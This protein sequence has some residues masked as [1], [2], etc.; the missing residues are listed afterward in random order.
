[1]AQPTRVAL[2]DLNG[3][4]Y[5]GSSKETFYRYI[6][7]KHGIKTFN[8][9]RQKAVGLLHQT[10]LMGQ[11]E[12]KENFFRYLDGLPPERVAQ[13]AR[14]FWSIEYPKHFNADLLTRVKMLRRDGVQVWIIS[15]AYEVYLMPLGELLEVDGLIG[16]KATYRN[17]RYVTL[18]RAA[19]D[20][21]KLHRLD[22]ELGSGQY[23]LTEAYSD[24]DETVLRSAEAGFEVRPDGVFVK[25]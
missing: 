17:G 1:M 6:C 5:L 21:E 2:F 4:L 8:V 12:F 3:C 14:E 18:G 22:A 11:T 15:G 16:T 13:Y 7:F 24:G 23:V 10:G 9:L 19:K 20:Q 25:V